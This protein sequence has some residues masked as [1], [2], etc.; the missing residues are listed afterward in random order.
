MTYK[1]II[2]NIVLLGIIFFSFQQAFS[3]SIFSDTWKLPYCNWSECGYQSWVKKVRDLVTSAETR[4][5]LS[6]YIQKVIVYLLT[7]ISIVWVIFIIYAWFSILIWWWNDEAEKKS[8]KTI[9]QVIIWII[10]IW[11][12]YS[13]VDFIIWILNSASK[14]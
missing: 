6:E 13:I 1:S 14:N 9:I 4:M 5:T 10:I 7:F 11:L 3:E 8:R 2:R 12:A